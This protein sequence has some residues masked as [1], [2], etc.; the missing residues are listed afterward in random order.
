MEQF[1]NVNRNG[2]ATMKSVLES[3]MPNIAN[4]IKNLL[5]QIAGFSYQLNFH[6]LENLMGWGLAS[7]V[8]M[9]YAS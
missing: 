1:G 4:V 8:E 9:A 3:I 2:G 5:S 7:A 6:L